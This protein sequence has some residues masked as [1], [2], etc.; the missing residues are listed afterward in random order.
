MLAKFVNQFSLSPVWRGISSFSLLRFGTKFLTLARLAFIARF[1]APAEIG[2]YQ[3]ALL[4]IAVGEIFTETGINLML[5]KHPKKLSQ[6]LDTAWVVS[7]IRGLLISV[8]V[9]ALTGAV[10]RYYQSPALATFLYVSALI[11]FFR[12]FINPAIIGFQQNLQF[13]RESAFR[14]GLQL[15]DIAIGAVLAWYLQSAVGLIIGLLVGVLAEVVF[16]FLLFPQWPN[17]LRANFGLV[18]KLYQETKFIIGNG[19]L[20]Y[21]TENLDDLVVG[22]VLGTAGLGLYHAAYRL[23]SAVTNDF[24]SIVGQVLYPVYARRFA[25]KNKISP[26]V[27]KASVLSL[28]FYAAVGIPLLLF[29]RPIIMLLLGERWLETVPL[30]RLLFLAG[31]I[32]SFTTSWNPLAILADR[33]HHHVIL[34]VITILVM[35]GGILWLSPRFGIVGAGWAVLLAVSL[36]QP[37]AWFITYYSV[38]KLDHGR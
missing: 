14:L 22:K 26:L 29:T 8:A 37:Y 33:L 6:Y 38:R 35:T 30:V 1:L 28:A 12:G 10:S 32:K 23:S 4:V 13:G 31:V 2:S 18:R 11:P 16:S 5:L 15:V 9:V 36:V 17:P 21:L 7:I 20:H 27:I 34:N 24:G 25:A 19:I 3:L